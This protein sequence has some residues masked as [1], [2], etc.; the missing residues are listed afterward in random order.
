MPRRSRSRNIS[1][2]RS[3][4]IP[5]SASEVSVSRKS[6]VMSDPCNSLTV[7]AKAASVSWNL[8]QSFY[9]NP[10]RKRGAAIP[11]LRFGLVCYFQLK[12]PRL[13]RQELEL[14]GSP[15]DGILCFTEKSTNRKNQEPN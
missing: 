14:D 2:A 4:G 8:S 5:T 13:P 1:F 12:F 15:V 7:T 10:K 3:G 11:R 6:W 9:S